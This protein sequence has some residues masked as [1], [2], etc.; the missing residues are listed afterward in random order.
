MEGA[1]RYAAAP[2]MGAEHAVGIG[3]L[4][5]DQA[6]DLGGQFGTRR[7]S[8]LHSH[9]LTSPRMKWIGIPTQSGR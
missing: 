7:R 6:V 2:G 9:L 1:H 5:G 3:V 8:L 4:T